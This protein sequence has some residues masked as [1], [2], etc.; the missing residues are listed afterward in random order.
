MPISLIEAMGMGVIPVC[1]PAGGVADGGD[2]QIG[3]LSE[4]LSEDAYY[5]AL[6]RYLD[7]DENTLADMRKRLLKTYEL[8]GM[9]ECASRY[10]S[11]FKEQKNG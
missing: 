8:Y 3:F 10:E 7:T 11:L 1:T 6:K 9:S 5:S 4:Y 2:G